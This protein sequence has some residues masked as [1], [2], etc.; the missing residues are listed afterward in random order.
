MLS[1]KVN[2]A[3][4]FLFERFF[5]SFHKK[6]SVSFVLRFLVQEKVIKNVFGSAPPVDYVAYCSSAK[7]S[8]NKKS[9]DKRASAL[10]QVADIFVKLNEIIPAVIPRRRTE[11]IAEHSFD[12][13]KIRIVQF[14]DFTHNI[15]C[16]GRSCLQAD[17]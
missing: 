11:N 7:F 16:R 9:E 4:A 10:R 17:C 12:L 1:L 13:R 8:V 14:A 3:Y 6:F 2:C 5:N 15:L